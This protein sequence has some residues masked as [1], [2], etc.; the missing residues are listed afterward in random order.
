M[1]IRG[2]EHA[3]A[4]HVLQARDAEGWDAAIRVGSRELPDGSF[5]VVTVPVNF[6]IPSRT[7]QVIHRHIPAIA[8]WM[9]KSA[10]IQDRFR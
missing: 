3:S 5:V 6:P 7:P 4:N 8:G 1:T 9:G 10:C 2:A